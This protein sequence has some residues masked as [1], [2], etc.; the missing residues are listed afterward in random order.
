MEVD[1]GL[2]PA[3]ATAWRTDPSR[4]YGLRKLVK[5][6]VRITAAGLSAEF[7]AAAAITG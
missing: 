1:E 5:T 2:P 7:A 3:E 6:L 4:Y